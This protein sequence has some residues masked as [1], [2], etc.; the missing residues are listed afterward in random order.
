VAIKGKSRKR[1]KPK[2]PAL[3]PKPTVSS[4]KTPLPLRRN[5]KRAAVIVLAVLAFMG[6]LRVWQNVSRSDSLRS[7]DKRISSAQ[8]VFIRYFTP[9]APSGVDQNVQSFTSGQLSAESFRKLTELWETDFRAASTAIGKLKP[10]NKVVEDSQFL[11][12]QG[13]DGY[14][15]VVRL[16]NLAAQLRGLADAE[17]DVKKKKVLND[18]VQVVLLQADDVRKG[19]AESLYARGATKLS[20]LNVEWGLQKKQDTQQQQQQQQQ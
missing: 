10:P 6:G 18:K 11:I 9:N 14:V 17:K 13:V 12:Q 16:W 5:V 4:R 2:P 19:T 1:S 7:Y 15:R 20:D 3:P 8:T